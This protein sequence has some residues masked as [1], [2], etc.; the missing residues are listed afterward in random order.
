MGCGG[1]WL[2]SGK[3]RGRASWLKSTFLLFHWWSEKRGVN[4]VNVKPYTEKK[5][6]KKSSKMFPVRRWQWWNDLSG[7]RKNHWKLFEIHQRPTLHVNLIPHHSPIFRNLSIRDPEWRSTW[8]VLL[9]FF[10]GGVIQAGHRKRSPQNRWLR[11][12]SK[13]GFN[14]NAKKLSGMSRRRTA[15]PLIGAPTRWGSYTML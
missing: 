6:K 14:P 2:N 9:I 12:C 11:S 10:A 8:V 3:K 4:N 7:S 15:E 13:H 1:C 5:L